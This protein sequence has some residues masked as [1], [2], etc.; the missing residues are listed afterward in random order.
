MVLS[1][2]EIRK[3]RSMV[4]ESRQTVR[5]RVAFSTS[6]TADNFVFKIACH[7]EVQAVLHILFLVAYN[8]SLSR[9]YIV[10][11]IVIHNAWAFDGVCIDIICNIY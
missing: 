8:K 7:R 3:A 5:V 10:N 6:L 4:G 2:F 9:E 11:C 1:K